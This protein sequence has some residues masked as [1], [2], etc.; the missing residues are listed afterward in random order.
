MHQKY[1]YTNSTLRNNIKGQGQKIHGFVSSLE[2]LIFQIVD[3]NDTAD[4]FLLS[5]ASL[6]QAGPYGSLSHLF[7]FIGR[8]NGMFISHLSIY[9]GKKS[10]LAL[11]TLLGLDL[12]CLDDSQF[13]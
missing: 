9:L 3:V 1:N 8:N 10:I 12:P 4:N 13:Y 6:T 5:L 11:L 2:N 7:I